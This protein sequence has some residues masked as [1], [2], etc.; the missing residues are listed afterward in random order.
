M[1]ECLFLSSIIP[2]ILFQEGFTMFARLKI[3][4]LSPNI[5]KLHQCQYHIN[6]LSNFFFTVVLLKISLFSRLCKA[7]FHFLFVANFFA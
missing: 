1:A 5:I 3:N 4:K 2:A 6:T 7:K